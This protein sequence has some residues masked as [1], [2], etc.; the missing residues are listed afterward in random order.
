MPSDN[1][2]VFREIAINTVNKCLLCLCLL[3]IRRERFAHEIYIALLK[4]VK[5][6]PL[7]VRVALGYVLPLEK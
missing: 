4:Y 6:L 1:R 3:Y 2:Y 7:V 5:F